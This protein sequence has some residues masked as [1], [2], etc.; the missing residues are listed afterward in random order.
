MPFDIAIDSADNDLVIES[1]DFVIGEST[2]QH[3]RLLLLIEKG[4]LR[5]FPTRGVGLQSWLN[6]ERAGDLNGQIKREYEIDGMDVSVI[7]T[8]NNKLQIEAQYV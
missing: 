7:Q 6:D 5:E 1:G 8:V 2:L 3:Q 4:E